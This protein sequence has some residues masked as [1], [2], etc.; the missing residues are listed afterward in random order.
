MKL[1]ALKLAASIKAVHCGG[2]RIHTTGDGVWFVDKYHKKTD[3]WVCVEK[4]TSPEAAMKYVNN[5]TSTK[6]ITKGELK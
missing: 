2:W 5:V 1:K 6:P 4:A 3:N